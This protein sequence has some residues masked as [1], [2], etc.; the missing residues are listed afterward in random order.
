[1]IHSHGKILGVVQVMNDNI[2]EVCTENLESF[3]QFHNCFVF[4][5]KSVLEVSKLLPF[6]PFIQEG[7]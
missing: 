6:V 5:A 3:L 7:G 2:A 1:M 4:F